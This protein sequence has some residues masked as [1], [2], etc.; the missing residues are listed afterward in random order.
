MVLPLSSGPDTDGGVDFDFD[1][2]GSGLDGFAGSGMEGNAEEGAL[3]GTLSLVGSRGLDAEAHKD[4]FI[5]EIS[6]HVHWCMRVQ[7]QH[8][9]V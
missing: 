5:R 6:Q 9:L 3:A 2:L 7:V 8:H 1:A 4:M